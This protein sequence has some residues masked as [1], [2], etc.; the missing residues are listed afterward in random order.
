VASLAA[1]ASFIL[2]LLRVRPPSSALVA[3]LLALLGANGCSFDALHPLPP[4][5]SREPPAERLS[6]LGLFEGPVVEQRPR[7]GLVPYDVNASLDADG[8]AKRRF[9]WVPRGARLH[10]TADRWDLPTGTYLVKTFSFP[11]DVRRP[12]LGERRIETRFLVKTSDGFL[13]STYLWNDEQTDAVVSGGNIDVPVSWIDETGQSRRQ[14]YHV[15]GTSQCASCHEGRALGIRSRQLDHQG[16]Y[17]GG[18]HDQ[19]THLAALGIIDETLPPHVVLADPVGHAPLELRARSYLD[20]HCG[21]CHGPGGSA[22]RTG[23]LWDLEHT[24]GAGLPSC[25]STSSVDGR[26][27]VLVPG[28]PEASEFLA[29]MRSPDLDVRMPRGPSRTDDEAGIALLSSWVAAMKP[30]RCE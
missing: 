29:R 11:V 15:P 26:D 7:A 23:V 30:T 1:A 12:A 22:E 28:H 21:H 2:A 8:A 9:I 18:A 24:S 5:G 10:T 20:S 25:R 13:E 6:Q 19:I 14:N 17:P 27:H 3:G 16:D 4:P